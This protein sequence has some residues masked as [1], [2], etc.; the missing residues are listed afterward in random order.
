MSLHDQQQLDNARRKLRVLDEAYSEAN[1]DTADDEYVR[2]LE[3]ESL[4]R[5]IN[6]LREEIARYEAQHVV[7][8]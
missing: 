1:R 7:R 2:T 6:Q 3:L 4:K 8:Q 5:L